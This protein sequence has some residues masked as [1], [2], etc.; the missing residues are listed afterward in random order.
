MQPAQYLSAKYRIARLFCFSSVN[1]TKAFDTVKTWTFTMTCKLDSPRKKIWNTCKNS[2]KEPWGFSMPQERE[3]CFSRMQ[4]ETESDASQ[5]SVHSKLSLDSIKRLFCDRK[6]GRWCKLILA[7]S[8]GQHCFVNTAE[9]TVK[10]Y[11]HWITLIC[12]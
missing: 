5:E 10:F 12:W 1:L 7:S 11:E 3:D 2:L 8:M 9:Q 6:P 4:P